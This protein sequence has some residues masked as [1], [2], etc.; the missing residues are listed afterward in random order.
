MS[1]LFEY[2]KKVKARELG[3]DEV[4]L[5]LFYLDYLCKSDAAV[6]RKS[7]LVRKK[8]NARLHELKEVS[9]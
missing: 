1:F 2:I 6:E 9:R 7:K 4:R 5:H 3:V 8:L